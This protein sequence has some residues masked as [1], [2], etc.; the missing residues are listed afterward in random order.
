MIELRS[1]TLTLPTARMREAMARAALGD[2]GYGE[3]PTVA[4]LEEIAA[5]KVGKPAA[6]FMPSGTMANLCALLAH[7]P[8]GTKVLVGDESDI[9]RYEAGG[10]SVVGGVLYEPV[11]NRPD[12]TLALADLAASCS[13]DPD[14]PQFAPPSLI[15]LENTHN[16]CGGQVLSL[17]YLAGVRRFADQHELALHLDGARLFNAAV[18]SGQPAARIAAHADSVQLDRK[19]VV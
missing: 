11:P 6:C 16:R 2:D 4:A 9:Y 17:P 8:R 18:A 12:G 19:S 1:D 15:C 7:A 5:Q 3:D 14:D 13:S 10:A